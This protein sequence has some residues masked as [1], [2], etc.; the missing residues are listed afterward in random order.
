MSPQRYLTH[1]NSNNNNNNNQKQQQQQQQ[2]NGPSSTGL[3]R[4]TLR[5]PMGIVF[6]PM[7]DPNQPSVQKGVRICDLP[8]TG[9]AALSRKL[10]IG[11]E[12]LS[13]NDKTMSRLT[14]DEIMDFIIE[15]D[16]EQVNL[17]F[18]RPRKEVLAARNAL[19]APPSNKYSTNAN[20]ASVKWVDEDGKSPKRD[21]SKSKGAVAPAASSNS[22]KKKP[23]S[24]KERYDDDTLE[25]YDE[26]PL[27][28]KK[29]RRDPYENESFLDLLIDTICANPDAVCKP[30]DRHGENDYDSDEDED[31][32]TLTSYDDSTYVTYESEKEK[33]PSSSKDKVVKKPPPPSVEDSE[34]E[35]DTFA[36][37][38]DRRRSSLLNNVKSLLPKPYEDDATLETTETTDQLPAKTITNPSPTPPLGLAVVQE[39]Q[40]APQP[41]P[42]KQQLQVQ[43]QHHLHQQQQQ[44]QQPRMPQMLT[45]MDDEKNKAPIT[46]L[47]YDDQVDADVSVMESLGGPSL[48]IEQ[49]RQHQVVVQPPKD[50]VPAEIVNEF[51][52][53][54]PADFGY[55]REQTIGRDPV[56]FYSYVV[57][58]LL[59]QHEPEKVRLL[60]KLLA[61]YK[62]RED[63][64]VQKLSVR[65]RRSPDEGDAASFSE[66]VNKNKESE[67]TE[68]ALQ[69]AQERAAASFGVWPEKETKE[70]E[71]VDVVKEESEEETE[72][73]GDSIDGTSPAVIAQVSELLNY[74]YGKTSVPGQIDR[75][76]TIMRAYE[77]REAVLLE[78]LE[79]KALIKANSEKENAANL[80]SF[81][82]NSPALDQNREEDDMVSPLSSPNTGM[83]QQP[84]GGNIINDDVSSMSG[85]SSPVP[86][87]GFK[88]VSCI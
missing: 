57:K 3:I 63:H 44:Q 20:A 62:G 47:E 88:P 1:N 30:S 5:K 32:R 28:K 46:E 67:S 70:Q 18:R 65:Y 42:P 12:L 85:V 45:S 27:P 36:E 60:D 74:V 66:A 17:L 14:F 80:P 56:R 25:T 69:K 61:K 24:K 39:V 64:L 53:E 34:T 50:V 59:E 73:S 16:P 76:S 6:E 31:D 8:R 26:K 87:N 29:G 83:N 58:K 48:L 41:E 40:P 77:G 22:K 2:D 86:E 10:E 54:Y 4:L 78:L 33:K 23:S 43:M 52:S 21:K 19:K 82:R 55:T 75:V 9:A 37:E 79:T 35:D 71:P 68:R 38:N 13:I 11:D 49:R 51:G 72:F 15:A 84:E 81:L 7:Y